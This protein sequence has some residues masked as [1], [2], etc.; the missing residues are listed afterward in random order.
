[1]SEPARDLL[2]S[3]LDRQ[4]R[5][6]LA[7]RRPSVEALLDGCPLRNDPDAQLDLLYNE[8]VLREDLGEEAAADEYAARYPHLREALAR[9]FEVHDAVRDPLLV[10]TVR[11][12]GEA[13]RPEHA[14]LPA[15]PWPDLPNYDLTEVLGRGGM[16]VVYQA[17]DRRLRRTVAV[18][19]FESGRVPTPREVRRFR[20][21]A[22]A[23]ARLR[24][25][26]VIQIFEVGEAGGVPFIALELAEGGTLADRLRQLP[27]PPR[28]AA[29]LVETLARAVHHAHEHGIIHRDL[30][31]ANV[32]F[33][34]VRSQEAGVS[35]T[36]HTNGQS[37]LTPDPCLLTPK[38]SDFGL[39]RVRY[40]DGESPADA[41]RTGEAIGTPRYMAPEQAAGRG[42]LVGPRTD[43]YALG[44]LLYEC[45]TG[46]VPFLAASVV[47]TL[48]LI[49]AADPPPPRR[50]Q[51]K[52]P[53]DLETICLHCLHKE[54]ARRYA[55]AASLADDLRR[56][57][58]R[59]PIMARPTPTW[60]RAWA[61]CRRRPAHA[62][63]IAVAVLLL[64]GGITAAAIRDRMERERVAQARAEV[65]ALIGDGQVAL[66]RDE[67]DVAEARFRDAWIIVQG[68]P[69]LRDYQTGVAGWLDHSRR[70]VN[71]QRWKQ[72]VP[73]RE[74]DEKRDEAI[75]LGLLLDPPGRDGVPAA[76]DAVAAALD[77]TIPNDP[78][79]QREREQL[80]LLDAALIH[81]A[82]GPAAALGRLNEPG[83]FSSRLF[84]T[85]RADY[86]DEL[87]RSD[88]AA[89]ERHR[90][91]QFPPDETAARLLAGTDRLRRRDF[92][93][94]ARDFEAVL[95]AE[96]EHFAARLFL[97]LCA[98]HRDRPGE[99][100]VGLTACIAQRP[101]FAWNYVYRGRCAEK[102]GDVAAARRDFARAAEFQPTTLN[103]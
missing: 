93:A 9:L 101:R 37:S 64:A 50:F 103:R 63:L 1:M 94:A 32:L 34:G 43:V 62:A 61:W 28:A 55:T 90:A 60:E 33:I 49:R 79:W 6:W 78:A 71:R 12:A 31:P 75:L 13:T 76:R 77:L 57:L 88:E 66:A 74:Y 95:D 29:E 97:S 22:E 89:A 26:N 92:P 65:E 35:V 69:A 45:L 4:G 84:H 53:R 52:V 17:R 3:L 68:E 15:A 48:D 19:T 16:G 58:N 30:K 36:G 27:P 56:F 7:G 59:E 39:A 5:E 70:A 41:T 81:A 10:Q 46:R 98:L 80:V 14:P 100:R 25:P 38:V 24:H 91:E 72:R 2:D 42:D 87:G 83:E 67:D 85:R 23:T 51:P 96:P 73:P 18:K 47:E 20:A 86:L 54:P 11:L 21:E 44:T 99:A 40:D 102:L 82:D 8:I